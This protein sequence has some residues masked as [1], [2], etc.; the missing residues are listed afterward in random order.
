[1]SLEDLSEEQKQAV[2]ELVIL[3]VK[4][5]RSQIAADIMATIPLWRSKGWAKSRRTVKAFQASAD[6]ALG[7]NE[8]I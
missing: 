2:A 1:M 8:L 7:R 4:E 6:I 3:T 5:I